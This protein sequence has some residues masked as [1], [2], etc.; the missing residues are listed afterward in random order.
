MKQILTF[1][2]FLLLNITAF[3]Q[4]KNLY[5]ISFENIEH[6]EAQVT[7]KFKNVE[8]GT[9]VLQMA[10]K[11][12]GS[13]GM[14]NFSKN[15]YDVKITGSK[16]K[17]IRATQVSL[18]RWRI[19]KHD[20]EINVSYKIFGDQPDEIYS[21]FSEKQTIINNP[22][23]FMYV[24]ALASRPVEVTYNVR[25]DLKWKI[26][27][28]LKDKGGNKFQAE[29]LQEFMDSPALLSNFEL[30]EQ[31][32]ES[33]NGPF[34]LRLAINDSSSK[35]TVDALFEDLVKLAEEQKKVFGSFPDYEY[36]SYTFIAS[37]GPGSSVAN[38]EHR[39]SSLILN[40][41]P[42]EKIRKLDR[43]KVYSEALV[44]SWN[45]KRIAPSSLKNFDFQNNKLTE[46]YWF[47]EGFSNYYGLIT[48]CRAGII[49]HDE[50]LEKASFIV[51]NV[52]TSSAIKHNNAIEMSK[53][54][55]SF[56]SKDNSNYSENLYIPYD[57]H[58][59]VIALILDLELREKED[60]SLDDF[61]NLLW[62][63]YGKTG[64]GYSTE[65]LRGTL[66]EYTSD[67]FAESFFKNNITEPEIYEV[68]KIMSSVGVTST[69]VELPF[70]GVEIKFNRDSLAEIWKYTIPGTPAY[71]G[72]L[73]K[74]DIILSID[75]NTFTNGAE[76][77]NAIAQ[78]K[79]A[80]KI[81]IV[82]RRNGVEDKM[83]MKLLPNPNLILT[84][85]LGA[86][87]KAVERKTSWIGE[88]K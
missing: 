40:K 45:K 88:E 24:N 47:T 7:A 68:S 10:K 54:S 55:L 9:V 33:A 74:G 17:S 42:L 81:A 15:I 11:T 87:G 61:M 53:K 73:E 38:V 64:M 84:S 80:T 1:I 72:G 5:T 37:Y 48:M 69:F 82:Y 70:I 60:L 75:G 25:K 49:S 20:G 18:S 85:D 35:E 83:N 27:T 3:S 12:P 86:S 23:T 67:S 66:R 6:H 28:Q 44:K 31:T 32:I 58:G 65:N 30:K 34:K 4:V 79:I 77:K 26:A 2:S 46:E 14:Y 22:A 29:N 41:K 63:K 56:H 50:F 8:R 71:E 36:D 78:K 76:F 21:Q 51:N 57:D 13:Y 62:S 52:I 39:N 19:D 43:I 16:G 59:F